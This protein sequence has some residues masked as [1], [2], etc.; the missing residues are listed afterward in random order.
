MFYVP[1]ADPHALG[2]AI[3]TLA[4]DPERRAAMVRQARARMR[5]FPVSF[6]HTLRHVA[7]SRELLARGAAVSPPAFTPAASSAQ[8]LRITVGIATSGRPAILRETIAELRRQSHPPRQI[9]VCAPT[10]ADV[11]GLSPAPDLQILQGPRG[12]AH[13]RNVILDHVGET[14]IILFFDDDFLPDRNY[15]AV[16]ADAFASAPDIVGTTGRVLADGAKGPGLTVE[17]ARRMLDD[18]RINNTH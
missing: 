16:C 2:Q 9:I 12:L 17:D 11:A 10:P 3:A 5:S 7:L 13:Q 15:L 4:N 18:P 6:T 14:D 1:P 8:G